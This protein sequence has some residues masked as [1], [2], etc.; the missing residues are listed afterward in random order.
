MCAGFGLV[1]LVGKIL[2][3]LLYTSPL[4]N[5]ICL[6]IMGSREERITKLDSRICPQFLL[7]PGKQ[8]IST[9]FSII[10]DSLQRFI[11]NNN[12][13]PGVVLLATYFLFLRSNG[14]RPSVNDYHFTG[15][16]SSSRLLCA[17][18]VR[19]QKLGTDQFCRASDFFDKRLPPCKGCWVHDS[20]REYS[21]EFSFVT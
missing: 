1:W 7:T 9:K 3:S 8:K 15:A 4:A 21:K 17:G 12:R 2:P 20:R 10:A 11:I 5:L 19:V 16:S 14:F 6:H 13:R 18:S